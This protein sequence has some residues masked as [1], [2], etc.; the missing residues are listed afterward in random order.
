MLL[1]LQRLESVLIRFSKAETARVVGWE[2]H[3]LLLLLLS[4]LKVLARL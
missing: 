3:A 2:M 1:T 4:L